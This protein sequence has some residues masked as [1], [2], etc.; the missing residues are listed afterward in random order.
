[1]PGSRPQTLGESQK[2][3]VC[4]ADLVDSDEE[5]ENNSKRMCR[6]DVPS[7]GDVDME[8][9]AAWEPNMHAPAAATTCITRG[10]ADDEWPRRH[11]KR[12]GI[13]LR[14]KSSPEYGYEVLSN[15]RAC[16]RLQ[17]EALPSTPDAYDPDISKRK[18]EEEVYQWKA[19][20][21]QLNHLCNAS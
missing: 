17:S 10:A 16:G 7:T 6:E 11:E 9:P 18:W 8:L 19:S 2:R 4:W 1:M 13:V 15:L 3:K 20:L 14:V 5:G 12:K 21:R